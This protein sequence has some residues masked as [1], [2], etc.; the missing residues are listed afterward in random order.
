MNHCLPTLKRSTNLRATAALEEMNESP[1]KRMRQN[2]TFST[3]DLLRELDRC[4]GGAAFP[5][6]EWCFDDATVPTDSGGALKKLSRNDSTEG[7]RIL[8]SPSM[9]QKLSELQAK[10]A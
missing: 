3:S 1:L 9:F 7:S 4:D 5:T 8:R 2:L 6:I 10:A